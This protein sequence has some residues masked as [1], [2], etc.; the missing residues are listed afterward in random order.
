MTA[1]QK[2][3][4]RKLSMLQLAE[5]LRNVSEACR[6]MGYSR[7]QFY[8]IKRSFQE[9]GFDGLLDKPPVPNTVPTRTPP[10]IEKKVI[11]LSIQHPSWGQQRVADELI[12]VNV[13][14]A[15]VTVRNIWLRHDLQTRYKRLLKLEEKTAGKKVKLTEEQI[16]LLEKHNPEFKERHVE[17]PRPGYLISQDTFF[18]GV[19]KGV[20]RIYLQAAVDT[21]CSLAFGKLYTAKI[22]ITAADLLNDR[23][24]PFYEEEGVDINAVLTD[25]GTEFK[26][27]LDRHAYELFLELNDIEHRLCK[28]AT[29]RTNGFVERFNR[30]VLDE[31]FR[32]A[33][34]KK[35]YASVEE[36]QADLDTW[37][38]HYNHQRPHR[39]YRN[40]G[41]RPYETFTQGKK[42][43]GKSTRAKEVKTGKAA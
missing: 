36:L 15:P 21:F 26:G 9:H 14:L 33:F 43:T 40:M 11:D 19:M 24:L 30:T 6:I 42:L 13:Q 35:F 20:G 22:P 5:K 39:G 27:R 3:A 4:H 10:E 25:R 1:K 18:V 17:S 12:L 2:V 41:R 29:P 34:R 37:L 38:D 8:E 16:R 32:E 23:V 7:Q 31:F 28:V